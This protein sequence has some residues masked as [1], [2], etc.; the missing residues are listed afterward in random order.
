MSKP[1]GRPFIAGLDRPVVSAEL[2]RLIRR[3]FGELGSPCYAMLENFDEFCF[4]EMPCVSSLPDAQTLESRSMA[5]RVF[6][7][8]GEVRW[9]RAPGDSFYFRVILDAEPETSSG[10]DACSANPP[11]EPRIVEYDYNE[12][13]HLEE[14]GVRQIELCVEDH[15]AVLLGIST[16]S[17]KYVEARL[18]KEQS[19]PVAPDKNGRA[20][21]TFR[22]YRDAATRELLFE[23]F[24]GVAGQGA[25]PTGG[26]NNE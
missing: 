16:D 10:Q 9:R 12:P 15:R 17:S 3:Y 26:E 18:G 20:W 11:G 21:V 1:Q 5:G 22:E 25:A 8:N 24:V 14:N 7:T 19:Y 4:C 23:R 6:G 13:D 2:E